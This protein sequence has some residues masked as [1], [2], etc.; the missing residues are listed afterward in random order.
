MTRY[1]YTYCHTYHAHDFT[2]NVLLFYLHGLD[3]RQLEERHR[4][5]HYYYCTTTTTIAIEGKIPRCLAHGHHGRV[6][7]CVFLKW[8]GTRV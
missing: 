4:H 3:D 7:V 6:S 2:K 1:I 8:G 5:C